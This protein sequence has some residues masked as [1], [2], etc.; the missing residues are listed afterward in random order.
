MKPIISE[1]SEKPKLSFSLPQPQPPAS[2]AHIESR[3]SG[4]KAERGVKRSLKHKPANDRPGV[5]SVG[6]KVG[7]GDGT[8][9]ASKP[10]TATRE[11]QQ[12]LEPSAKRTTSRPSRTATETTALADRD[13][14]SPKAAAANG[15]VSHTLSPAGPSPQMQ[16]RD[17]DNKAE[18][19]GDGQEHIPVRDTAS[20]CHTQI[21]KT[22]VR[23]E[24]E[25]ENTHT[26][27]AKVCV[28]VSQY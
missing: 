28:G 26:N 13:I 15:K 25:M 21:N 10:A 24:N 7:S 2:P 4:G 8:T 17:V 11:D 1:S 20:A 16:P 12:P 22:Q 6:V 19:Q 3:R 18:R 14:H 9:T 23:C 5:D 27:M